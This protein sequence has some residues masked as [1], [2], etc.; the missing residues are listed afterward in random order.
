MKKFMDWFQK[1][2]M[3]ILTKIGENRVMI[4][5]RNG[6]SL[7]I[8]ITII[9]SIFNIIAY[10]PV[11]GWSE[12]LG[13]FQQILEIPATACM[14]MMAIIAVVGVSYNLAKEYDL[15][16]L[17]SSIVAFTTFVVTQT[18][19][20]YIIN[21]ANFGVNGLFL[22]M[23]V[24][25]IA[26]QIIRFFVRRNM[27]VKLP[28]SVPPMVY[29][30]FEMLIPAVISIS[31][32]W[33]FTG[34]LNIDLIA[35]ISVILSPLVKG[36]ASLPGLLLLFFLTCLL[37]CCGINGDSV[38]E[39]VAYPIFMAAL[40]E[41]SAAFAAG[42]A[43]PNI[44]AYGIHYFG[45]WMGG[46]GGTIGLV[47]LMVRSKAKLYNQLG[48][49]T[50]GPGIFCIN[51]PVTYGFPIVFNPIMMIPYILTP[52]VT[53]ALTYILMYFN[54][55]GRVVA[56]IP[57][58]TPPIL[59]AYLATGG[60]WRAALWQGVCIILSIIIYYPFFKICEKKEIETESSGDIVG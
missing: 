7:V 54:I 53:I 56:M 45:M 8:P 36:I 60:D 25:I 15:E 30:S 46:T 20:E 12:F 27:V 9:G 29:S 48:K 40:A 58:T 42:A 35:V 37:W 13:P 11:N 44:S 57:W 51:E 47:L 41:N 33:I 39:G 59:N 5:L 34:I 50:L 2:V 24:A 3:P 1:H 16:P 31:I 18:N 6:I 52:L 26:V 55:I 43:I 4:A 17:S 32:A 19:N 38:F 14:G 10:F 28:K 22:G 21:T 49:L 23:V